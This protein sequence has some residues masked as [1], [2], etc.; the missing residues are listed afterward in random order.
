MMVSSTVSSLIAT[1]R[2]LDAN[3]I[4]GGFGTLS[5]PDIVEIRNIFLSMWMDSVK[6][7]HMLFIDS[8]MSWPPELI[9][10]MINFDKPLV[11]AL[12]PK[13]KLP[14]EF[15]GRAKPGDVQVIN[16]FMEVNGI[17]GA[18]MLIKRE[19]VTAMLQKWPELSDEVTIKNHAAKSILDSHNVKR[20]IKAFNKLSINGE[21]FSEDLSFCHRWNQCGG[22]IWANITYPISHIGL[23]EY[24][25]AY[26]DQIKD[27]MRPQQPVA[28]PA[29]ILITPET[30]VSA[31]VFGSIV[32]PTHTNGAGVPA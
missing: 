26:Y 8:D 13:K 25:G 11:G 5:Y 4:N 2:M 24:Q 23:Y 19:V 28:Q 1:T 3:G 16:G 29:P 17:G 30:T 32:A 27:H 21:E 12:C 15:A 10:D 14:I 20:L 31:E 18:I 22:D 9:L 6:T 7:S